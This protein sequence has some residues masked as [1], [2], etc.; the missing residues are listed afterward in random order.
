[1]HAHLPG[2]GMN[3]R[4]ILKAALFASAGWSYASVSCAQILSLNDAINKAG[5][6]R[7]LSQRMAKAYLQIGMRVDIE[8]SKKILDT[9]LSLFDR[10]LIELKNFSTNADIKSAVLNIDKN[11][12]AYKDLLLG[13]APNVADGKQILRISDVLLEM[14]DNVTQQLEKHANSKAGKLVNISGRQRM[15]SQR[16]AKMYQ[17]I[18]WEIAGADTAS[19]L[20]TARKEFNSNMR[21]L[22][23]NPDNTKAIQNELQ[24]AQQQWVFFDHAIRQAP[25]PRMRQ[26]YATTVATTSERILQQMDIVTGQYEKLT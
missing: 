18:Q 12:I 6:Q 23:A 8:S 5:R 25:D 10:Q 1:M 21:L 20:E 17:A 2:V 19:S 22:D 13:K 3:R 9:S 24:F 7:M 16:M 15:L 14:T 26:Q 4:D 11:W